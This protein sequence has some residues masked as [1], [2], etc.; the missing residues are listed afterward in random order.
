MELYNLTKD[1][2][3][4]DIKHLLNSTPYNLKVTDDETANIFMVNYKKSESDLTNN[5]VKECRGIIMEKETNRV[6]CYTFDRKETPENITEFLENNWDN[7]QLS[8]SIDGSQIK[9]YYH[10]DMWNIATTRC[11]NAGEAFWY[12]N[13]SFETLF[14]ECH[15]LNYDNLNTDYCYSF[16]IRHSEN[17]IVTDYDEN[18]LVHVLTRDMTT[19]KYD[20]VEHDIGVAKPVEITYN[21][22][23]ELMDMIKTTTRTDIEGVFIRHGNKHVKIKFD[24][25]MNVKKLRNN[26]RDLFYEYI[27]IMMASKTVEYKKEFP[28]FEFDINYYESIVDDLIKKTHRLYMEVHVEKTRLIK[29]VD[30]S[31]H[32]HLYNL[33]GKYINERTKIN[34]QVVREFMFKLDAKQIMHLINIHYRNISTVK[35][36]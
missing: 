25:Y 35:P 26:T 13:K 36:E 34:R 24:A 29:A 23:L 27:E 2:S 5:I 7:L 17:R 10:N 9:L 19:E 3:Y 8:E 16:V 33:H 31:F 12:S 30:V 4:G 15:D 14:R 22:S 18:S 20:I 32:R 21:S 6:L 28:E 1:F 11:I